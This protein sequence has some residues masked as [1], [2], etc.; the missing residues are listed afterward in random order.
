[1]FLNHCDKTEFPHIAAKDTKDFLQGQ[2]RKQNRTVHGEFYIHV[3]LY[4]CMSVIYDKTPQSCNFY[5]I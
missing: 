2:A 3:S 4:S 1:M 5:K